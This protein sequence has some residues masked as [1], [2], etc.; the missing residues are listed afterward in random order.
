MQLKISFEHW[1]WRPYKIRGLLCTFTLK[2]REMAH[3]ALSEDFQLSPDT[4]V[5]IS[6]S[7]EPIHLPFTYF[8]LTQT[9]SPKDIARFLATDLTW[10]VC[11]AYM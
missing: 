9:L 10:V 4:I 7:V 8:L 5:L 3:P 11:V 1:K 2:T 6:P